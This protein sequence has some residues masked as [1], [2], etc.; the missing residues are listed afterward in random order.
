MKKQDADL[1]K[2]LKL[3]DDP[4]DSEIQA[5]LDELFVKKRQISTSL[6]YIGEQREEAKL[7]VTRSTIS[8]NEDLKKFIREKIKKDDDC[9][10]IF[11]DLKES[12]EVVKRDNKYW[13]QHGDLVIHQAT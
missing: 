3:G 8:I 7:L 12:V 11:E 2:I 1:V 6:H 4:T 10:K 13:I 5:T 9:K